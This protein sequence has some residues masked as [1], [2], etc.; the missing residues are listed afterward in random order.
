MPMSFT[1]TERRPNGDADFNWYKSR[2]SADGRIVYVGNYAASAATGRVYRSIDYGEHF[3]QINPTGSDVGFNIGGLDCSADGSVVI[4]GSFG[5]ET[6][7]VGRVYISTDYG[8]NFTELR[9]I[10][11]VARDW[12]GVAVSGDG[13]TILMGQNATIATAGRLW[14]SVAPFSAFTELRPLGDADFYWRATRINY[15]GTV[16]LASRSSDVD[17][18]NTYLSA[19]GGTNWTN[20]SIGTS[21]SGISME[22]AMSRSG[23]VLLLV[24]YTL[25]KVYFSANTGSSWAD[26]TPVASRNWRGAAVSQDG[27]KFCVTDNSGRVW[28]SYNQGTAWTELR[29][30]GDANK[31]W[32]GVGMSSRGDRIFL[33][34]Q[35]RFYDGRE[36]DPTAAPISAG[37]GIMT[38]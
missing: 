32:R 5:N 17:G 28:F 22:P 4:V 15:D 18:T 20:E 2:C 26:V 8:A 35:T 24:D 10:G 7:V 38:F 37:G 1:F 29:P 36:L 30:A 27:Q 13:N 6:S 31:S 34:S 33:T 9:P 11:D 16:M 25:Q 14:K 23:S 19:D 12:A 21:T 3:T